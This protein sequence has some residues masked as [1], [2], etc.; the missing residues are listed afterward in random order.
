MKSS[1][2]GKLL[3]R[4]DHLGA[5][6]LQTYLV[7]LARENGFLETVFR[8]L[9]D[10][11]LVLDGTGRIDYANPAARSMLP[12]PKELPAG[13]PIERYL[14]DLPW[15]DWLAE[16][17]GLTRR[18][19]IT[20]PDPRVVELVLLPFQNPDGAQA[21][22]R[23]AIFHDIT[24]A[25]S[26]A[27]EA[28][29]SQRLQAL[30]LLAAGVAHELGNPLN[31]LNIHLQL[32]QRD[33]RRLPAEEA[34]P[35]RDSI[36]VAR[37][38]LDRLDTIIH[39]FLRAIRPTKPDFQA[40]KL[41]ALVQETLE[42][43][44][45][46][47]EDRRLLVEVDIDAAVPE[48]RMD[49]VQM[50]QVFY[51]LVRNAMQAMG[52]RGLLRIRG[53]LAEGCVLVTVRDNGCGIALEDLPRV[54]EAYFTTKQGGSGLGLMIVQRIVQEHGGRMEIESHPGRGTVVRLRFPLGGTQVRL[55]TAEPGGRNDE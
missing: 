13:A 16:P 20:Y 41:D 44:H 38:E 19:D 1:F 8:T 53:E 40:C 23:V 7:R 24:R 49:P 12:L 11:I 37:R 31:S 14:R 36:E 32:I 54:T 47:I 4:V 29:E 35:I 26:S 2:L 43:L 48:L 25:E 3:E 28:I 34:G 51:N 21:D 6:E 55:L 46:E 10:G 39:Q 22:G 27:R 42:T 33:L 30:T 5:D 9:Q 18:L 15:G 45:A 17:K 52:P 50:K